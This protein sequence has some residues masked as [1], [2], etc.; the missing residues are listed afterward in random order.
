MY[1]ESNVCNHTKTSRPAL[2]V[3]RVQSKC[4]GTRW[5]TG[6]EVKG[7]GMEWVAS[8]L[9]T[10]SE[11]GVSSI[12]TA[13]T[14]TSAASSRLNWRPSRFKWTRPF[15]WK[16]KFG[17]CACAITFQTQSNIFHCVLK[18]PARDMIYLLMQLGCHPVAE[19]QFTFTHKQ[20]IERYKTN[21]T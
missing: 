17:F 3:L 15:H 12:T 21:N 20:Y 19:V 13:D 18:R 8:T 7:K 5:R 11:R 14:H 10:T 6:G 4:D 2:S 1:L 16:T 9:H